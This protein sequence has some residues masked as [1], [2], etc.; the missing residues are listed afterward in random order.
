[1]TTVGYGDVVP[2]TPEGRLAAVVLML[3]GISL[4]GAI[5]ATITSFMVAGH[6]PSGH[7]DA[8]ALLVRLRELRD[9]GTITDQEFA[10]K[11]R[12]LLERL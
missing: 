12:E 11:K 10:D 4:F 9:T 1:M 8:V 3:L 2:K 6:T 5:T 7:T